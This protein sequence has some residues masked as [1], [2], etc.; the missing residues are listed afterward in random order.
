MEHSNPIISCSIRERGLAEG[1][2][3]RVLSL[4]KSISCVGEDPIGWMRNFSLKIQKISDKLCLEANISR[5]RCV[6]EP[7]RT[8]IDVTYI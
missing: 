4:L 1:A 7:T 6:I 8:D 5:L 2:I 3:E